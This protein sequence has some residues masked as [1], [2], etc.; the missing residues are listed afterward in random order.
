MSSRVLYWSLIIGALIGAAL[1]AKAVYDY[2]VFRTLN[3]DGHTASATVRELKPPYGRVGRN[4]RW[5]LSYTFSTP[6]RQE[7]EGAVGIRREQAADLRVGE[8]IDVVYDPA[9]PAV[10][11]LNPEQAW[12]VVVY[13]ERVLIPYFALFMLLAWNALD[14]WRREHGT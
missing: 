3:D 13:N 9:D 14:R 11:A 2:Q 8:Q 5:V 7:V 1:V 10:S 4:G 6:D 12:A